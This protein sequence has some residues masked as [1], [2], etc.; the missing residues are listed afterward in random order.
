MPGRKQYTFSVQP[1]TLAIPLFKEKKKTQTPWTHTR[2]HNTTTHTEK[3]LVEVTA[4]AAHSTED[5]GHIRDSLGAG[6]W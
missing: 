4:I 6:L 2:P 3:K 5:Q 1:A